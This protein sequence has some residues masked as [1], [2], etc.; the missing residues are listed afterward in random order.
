MTMKNFDQGKKIIKNII[1]F[2]HN[3]PGVYKMQDKKNTNIY[4]KKAKN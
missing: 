1:Q 4:I 3:G 2:L